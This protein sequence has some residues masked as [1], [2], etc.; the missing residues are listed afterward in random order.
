MPVGLL[1]LAAAPLLACA[2]ATLP[3]IGGE[4]AIAAPW[5]ALALVFAGGHS[6]ALNIQGVRE[7]RSVSVTELPFV[8]GLFLLSPVA[9]CA[10]R[11]VGCVLGQGVGRGQWRRPLKLAFNTVIVVAEAPLGLLIFRGLAF[12]SGRMSPQTWA[13]AVVAAVAVSIFAGGAVALIIA[14]IETVPFRAAAIREVVRTSAPQGLAFGLVG[15]VAILS[16]QATKWAVLPLAL[17]TIAS[18]VLHHAYAQFVERHEN[19]ERL[20]GFSQAVAAQIHPDSIVT[21]LLERVCDMFF[22][23][24]ACMTMFDG[25]GGLPDTEAVV[26]GGGSLE[27]RPAS[28]LTRDAGWVVDHL[29]SGRPLLLARDTKDLAARHWLAAYGLRDAMLVPLRGEDGSAGALIVF[30]RRGDTR[31]FNREDLQLFETVANH[32]STAL[33][34]G[35]L[36]SRLRHDSLHDALTGVPNRSFFQERV[37]S[38]FAALAQGGRPFAVA[39]VDL[40]SFK[41]VND[42]LGHDH[43]DR[44][45]QEVAARFTDAIGGRGLVS[46]F[47]GDEFTVVLPDCEDAT[48]A[49]RRCSALLEVLAEPVVIDGLTLDVSASV[50]VALAPQQASTAAEL[51]RRADVAMYVAKQ[52]RGGVVAYDADQDTCSP[53]RLALAA[54][55]RQAIA[56]RRLSVYVQ[57]QVSL[58]SGEV[59]CVEALTRWIDPERGFVPPDEFIPLAERAGLIG[60]LTDFVLD[61]AIGACAAWQGRAPGV[62]V[63][64]NLSAR[65]L[66][67]DDLDERVGSLLRRH[68]LA[69]R[70]LTLEITESTAMSDPERTIAVLHQLR[71]RG[72]RLSIDDFGTGYSSLAYLRRLPV[73]EVKVDRS[74]VLRMD[75]ET[76][77]A[78]IVRSILDLA[79]ALDLEVVAEGVETKTTLQMLRDFGCDVA[80]GYHISRPMPVE[81]FG[82]WLSGSS[83]SASDR[84]RLVAVAARA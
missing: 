40:D 1:L 22:A 20:H 27:R 6:L 19:A 62:G 56:D 3:A 33:R 13:A 12:G 26:R 29:R 68:G 75:V 4:P 34:H 52:E 53:T 5:W 2:A 79:R 71:A 51:L 69:A 23:G 61:Q 35:E 64:V 80:Q 48:A 16:L 83:W 81:E 60:P 66:R 77:D 17:V 11:F 84:R 21:T 25:D 42:T 45:L 73:Q 82:T 18:V 78:A 63:A 32:G 65:S 15:V 47:G 58:S 59:V 9:F 14:R 44:L 57:P 28:Y 50:G 46:R 30:D 37:E 55:L 49:V 43:G 41:E 76:E 54:A 10:A 70:L 36:V 74:F 38:L 7:T 8:L 31:G 24:G 72:V 39:M 67:D